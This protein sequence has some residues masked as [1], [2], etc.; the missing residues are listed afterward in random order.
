V[1]VFYNHQ[2][3]HSQSITASNSF[4]TPTLH[5]GAEDAFSSPGGWTGNFDNVTFDVR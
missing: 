4:G 1:E 5:I 3:V 2:H